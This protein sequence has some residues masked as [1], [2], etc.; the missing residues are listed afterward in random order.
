MTVVRGYIL[1]IGSGAR[2]WYGIT[3]NTT[4]VCMYDRCFGFLGLYM[5]SERIAGTVLVLELLLPCL[6]EL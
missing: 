6:F 1:A 5:Y 3:V 4:Y 2:D